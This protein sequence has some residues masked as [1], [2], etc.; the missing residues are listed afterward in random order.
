MCN[1][2]KRYINSKQK[3]KR[4][5]LCQQ[6]PNKRNTVYIMYIYELPLPAPTSRLPHHLRPPSPPQPPISFQTNKQLIIFSIEPPSLFPT[7]SSLQESVLRTPTFLSSTRST[8]FSSLSLCS[9]LRFLFRG[10]SSQTTQL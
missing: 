4:N 10:I 9:N 7:S 3:L 8:T 2:D 1:Q 6:S 5:N